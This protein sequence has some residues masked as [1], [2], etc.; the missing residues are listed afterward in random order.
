MEVWRDIPDTGGFYQASSEGRIRSIDRTVMKLN[1]WGFVAPLRI[2]GR[3]LK[4][5]PDAQGYGCVSLCV[6]DKPKAVGAHR[7]IA[8]TFHGD[9]MGQ[10]VNHKDG[11]KTNNR[12]NNLEWCTRS[13][14]MAHARD[15]GLLRDRLAIIKIA[16]DGS[17]EEFRSINEAARMTGVTRA[18]IQK[19]VKST[20][21]QARG[22]EWRLA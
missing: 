1:R 17:T 22:F 19:A 10:H 8:S 2:K 4:Q 20:F 9:G 5:W 15:T 11:C 3:I 13:E 21:R 16:P 18:C 6:D 14:N 12:P 7:L